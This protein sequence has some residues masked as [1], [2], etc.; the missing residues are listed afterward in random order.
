ML[1]ALQIKL[2]S[3]FCAPFLSLFMRIHNLCLKPLPGLVPGKQQ[4]GLN[5]TQPSGR[6]SLGPKSSYS[7]TLPLASGHS[8]FSRY[9][10]K[11]SPRAPAGPWLDRAAPA[12]WCSSRIS[13]PALQAQDAHTDGSSRCH[14]SWRFLCHI[15]LLNILNTTPDVPIFVCLKSLWAPNSHV[16]VLDWF[17]F[18]GLTHVYFWVPNPRQTRILNSLRFP[19]SCDF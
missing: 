1:K 3:F 9:C 2:F 6:F 16:P 11:M 18:I 4:M 12:S 10:S 19:G 5:I 13:P 17:T 7:A 8:C 14:H 15:L